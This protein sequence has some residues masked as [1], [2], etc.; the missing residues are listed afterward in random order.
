MREDG[1][2]AALWRAVLNPQEQDARKN[3]WILEA[4][5]R[6][7]DKRVSAHQYLAKD[8]YLIWRL[9]RTITASL[10]GNRRRREEETGKE[11]ETII[12]SP[13]PPPPGRLAPVKGVVSGCDRP[14]STARL[15]NP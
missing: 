1:I 9:G 13:P 3:A 8:Q 5:R 7:V 15:G 4:T 6:L 2:F 11:V 10:K 14:C 12:V